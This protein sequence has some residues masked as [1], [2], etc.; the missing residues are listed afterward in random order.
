MK[1]S[2]DS[3]VHTTDIGS[4]DHYLVWFELQKNFSKSR[5]K[6]KRSMYKWQVD[7]LQDKAIRNEYQAELD[8]Q[9]NDFFQ[10]FDDLRV[11]GEKLVCTIAS[12]WERW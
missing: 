8:V 3:F 12:K 11:T 10:T 6:A 5:N 1:A 9:A 4:S 2:S 7:R